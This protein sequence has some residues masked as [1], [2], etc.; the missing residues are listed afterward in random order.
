MT[1]SSTRHRTTGSASF[2]T[3]QAAILAG[4]ALFLLGL[5]AV[6]H[7]VSARRQ[8]L[9]V[10]SDLRASRQ[11]LTKRDDT[12][13]KAVLDR[14]DRRLNGASA[15]ASA[16]PL[17]AIRAVPLL[18]SPVRAS[19]TA[20]RAG[21]E[22]VAA[23]RTLVAASA[24][25]P[26]S[27]SSAVDGHD[28]A[29]FHAAAARSQAAVAEADR[30]LGRADAALAGPA[31]AFLPPV[32]SPARAMRAELAKGRTELGAVGRGLNLLA[33][34]TGPT[35][36]VRLL[37]LAQDTLELRPT[38]GFIGS[39]GILHFYRGTVTLENYQNAQDLPAPVP[40]ATAPLELA[41]WL[42]K[43]W[44]LTNA[45]WW[46]DFPTSAAAAGELFR[47]QGGGRVD[48][49]L[50]MTDLAT[51]R[52]IGALGSIQ[53][54]GYPKPVV[55]EGF[56]RRV[57][58]EVE[59]KRPLDEPRKKFLMDLSTA[60]FDRL[61]S[62]PAD[63]LPAVTDAVRRSIGAGDIQLWFADP[64]RQQT[65]A[66]TV[67]AGQ[68]PRTDGDMLMVVDANLLAGKANLD[69][70]KSVDY[71]V[72]RDREGRL[73]GRVRV[74]I[75]NEGAKSPLNLFYRSHLRVY[76]PAG[77]QLV[78][79]EASQGST[80]AVDGPFQVFSQDMVVEPES[81]AVATFDYVLPER[82]AAHGRYELTWVRQ[83][84]TPGDRLRVDVAGRSAQSDPNTRSLRIQQR[85][86]G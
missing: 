65:L 31:G 80:Q 84:G 15:S 42:P 8:L 7:L 26:T 3:R 44:G 86:A 72:E 27:A 57:V 79:S 14:A 35:S 20:V 40:A 28:L 38:G 75:R 54:P 47:R 29:A 68:L 43:A 55:E 70:R 39:Y 9:L 66:G 62:L 22:G 82:I 76:A 49:V 41:R 74:E 16:F 13:A 63:K 24:S 21:R 64:S 61:F 37:F 60:V 83:V 36:D 77:A 30:R 6:S 53:L 81:T 12:A 71:R 67:V 2:G 33:D 10:G 52:L 18:G 69:V 50:A 45:N 85:L 46:P 11:A 23:A 5:L 17:G 58:Y 19:I 1:S 34:L 59:L 73:I 48:G 56:A 4:L 51:A 78:Q 32:S 25:F